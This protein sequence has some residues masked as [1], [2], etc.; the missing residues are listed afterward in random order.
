MHTVKDLSNIIAQIFC[1][2]VWDIPKVSAPTLP[3]LCCQQTLCVTYGA[4]LW[5][6]NGGKIVVFINNLLDVISVVTQ[7]MRRGRK[8]SNNFHHTLK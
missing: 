8:Q 7:Q 1:L 2:P 5:L 3:Q 6:N 4:S